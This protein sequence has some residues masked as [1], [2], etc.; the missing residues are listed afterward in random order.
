MRKD[1]LTAKTFKLVISISVG[2]L[3]RGKTITVAV[4]ERKKQKKKLISIHDF[5][6]SNM[7]WKVC[8]KPQSMK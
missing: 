2:L 5:F 4:I 6:K 7:S 1:R 8:Q 3:I